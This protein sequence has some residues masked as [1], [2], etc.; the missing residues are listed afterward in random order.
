MTFYCKFF[1]STLISIGGRGTN[2]VI[3]LIQRHF[4]YNLSF[5]LL[6]KTIN[7]NRGKGQKL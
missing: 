1:F 3:I 6:R 7:N 5:Y 2:L 4:V